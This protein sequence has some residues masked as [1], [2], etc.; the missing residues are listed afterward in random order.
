MKQCSRYWGYRDK[1]HAVS[2][3][4]ATEN[5]EEMG[6]VQVKSSQESSKC[7]VFIDFFSLSVKPGHITLLVSMGENIHGKSPTK[8]AHSGFGVQNLFWAP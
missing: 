8:E 6:H 7:R 1:R 4:E 5:A 2:V 3:F